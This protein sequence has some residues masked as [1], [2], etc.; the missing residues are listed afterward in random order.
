LATANR[1]KRRF[2]RPAWVA[3]LAA[4]SLVQRGVAADKISVEA[5]HVS[6][7]ETSRTVEAE[8]SVRLEWK[9]STLEA[10]RLRV[11]Q[12]TRRI[13]SEGPL[14][15][16]MPELRLV[17]SSCDLDIDDETGKLTD[18]DMSV[19]DLGISFGGRE[20]RK[21]PGARYRLTDGYF[22]T[23][24]RVDGRAPD[25][26]LGGRDVD[27]DVGG[28]GKMRHGTF[29]IKD[30]PVLYLPY[31]VFPAHDN[32]QSG[33]LLPQLGASNQRGLVIDQPYFWAIDKHQDLT[34]TGAVETSARVGINADYRYRP[35]R[36]VEGE[37]EAAYYNEKIRENAEG[38][39][40]SP[41]FKGVNIPENR[42]MFGARHRQQLRP[43]VQLY[44]DA[45]VV[46][47]DLYLREI[48][49]MYAEYM[50]GSLRRTLRYTVNRG[51]LLAHR[52]F[53]SIGLRSIAYQDFVDT[54]KQTLQRPGE[55]WATL[56]G[57][58]GGIG[59]V[60]DG[61]FTRFE[62]QR[63]ADGF[64]MDAS[65][66][67]SRDLTPRTPLTSN[68]WLRGRVSGYQ[69]DQ[70]SVR[71]QNGDEVDELDDYAGRAV[72]ETGLDLRTAFAREFGLPRNA[73]SAA[74]V[75]P[76]SSVSSRD[77][78]PTMLHML[79]PFTGLRFTTSGDED[80]VPLYDE[81]DRID[82]RTT[83]TYGI[84]QR[85]LFRSGPEGQRE[86]RARLS[87]AQTYNL[88]EKVIDDHFSDV[89]VSMGIKPVGGVSVSGLTSYNPG[90][91]ELTGA[92]G[93][94]SVGELSIPYLMP[95]GAS[96]DVVYRF[97][98][99]GEGEAGTDLD[100]LETLEARALFQLTP[101]LAMGLNGRY[102]FPGSELVES[103]GG[104]RV[105]SACDC[106]AIDLGIVNRVNPD[107]TQ[108]R[109]AVHL[110]GL[111]GLGSSAL[112]YQTPGLA[113]VEHGRTI[114]GRYGW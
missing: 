50:A 74:A 63:G 22:T 30:V 34:L 89:D 44:G 32:R 97:V 43:N 52:G 108:V 53:S 2:L 103:G 92:V 37:I 79:E 81:Y 27:V 15:L 45:L 100:E 49:P 66:T 8:G 4:L 26:S 111:G 88:D 110:K 105:T 65:A 3:L 59:Y 96:L 104:F 57:D 42:W 35:R 99:G 75:G 16:T 80:Q 109:L 77:G 29:R 25:W 31:A 41:V 17:A 82:D 56:D 71:N 95:A 93:E 55:A 91:S 112:E 113:G 40:Q 62:R 5:D 28:Y 64:R 1:S 24:E 47:D 10:E 87:I 85:F 20:V 38:D 12:S 78:P 114:Y 70:T 7:D 83:F 102:D 14:R 60:V 36:D 68:V 9:G 86:E 107:E 33:I 84:A 61:E 39:I 69:L 48:D 11:E 58:V 23:C 76:P 6:Y 72:A 51:G 54:S 73:L 101:R 21:Y 18:V 46:S 98:R 19:E 67:L 106:W 13:L 94:L 90:A